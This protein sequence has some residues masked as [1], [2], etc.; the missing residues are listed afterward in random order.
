MRSC[1][2]SQTVNKYRLWSPWGRVFSVLCCFLE[3]S[4]FQMGPKHRAE[5]LSTGTKHRR[6][7]ISQGKALLDKLHSS[8]EQV[9]ML[10]TC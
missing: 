2:G 7:R 3:I 6:S 5:V 4:L 8:I 1:F 10:I 9:Y